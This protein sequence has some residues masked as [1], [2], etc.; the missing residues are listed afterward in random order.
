[1]LLFQVADTPEEV[2]EKIV[3]FYRDSE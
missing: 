3:A 1:M 2:V